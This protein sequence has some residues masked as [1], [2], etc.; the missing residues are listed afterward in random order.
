MRMMRVS[1]PFITHRR[2][3]LYNTYVCGIIIVS[4]YA[5]EALFSLK[6]VRNCFDSITAL[7]ATFVEYMGIVRDL[8]IKQEYPL[9]MAFLGS[10]LFTISIQDI[11]K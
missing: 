9:T 10:F 6:H 4:R 11:P 2:A 1:V 3:C 5:R 8:A 7:D